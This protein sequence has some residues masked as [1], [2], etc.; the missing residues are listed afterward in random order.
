MRRW[1]S[2]RRR[3][4]TQHVSTTILATPP[5][6]S[7]STESNS[8]S[9]HQHTISITLLK[10]FPYNTH[11]IICLYF[12]FITFSYYHVIH[13]TSLILLYKSFFFFL[14]P[15]LPETYYIRVKSHIFINL[16]IHIIGCEWF[17]HIL[18]F[19]HT[20]QHTHT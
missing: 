2:S 6:F 20:H 7:F 8:L 4:L 9:E 5:I 15:E 18:G 1:W 16:F 12:Y 19:T 10:S 11:I 14:E 13:I 17:K 3:F